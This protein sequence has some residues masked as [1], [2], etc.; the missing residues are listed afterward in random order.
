MDGTKDLIGFKSWVFENLSFV[1]KLIGDSSN[2]ACIWLVW[3]ENNELYFSCIRVMAKS[4]ISFF[5]CSGA[6]ALNQTIYSQSNL[7][8]KSNITSSDFAL[9]EDNEGFLL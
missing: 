9:L 5:V 1:E 3:I 2:N 7:F 6:I 8:I 4:L